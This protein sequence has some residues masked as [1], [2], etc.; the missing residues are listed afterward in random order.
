MN[1]KALSQAIISD[2][3]EAG[4]QIQPTQSKGFAWGIREA[5]WGSPEGQQVVQ[6]PK[7]PMRSQE[8]MKESPTE[9]LQKD[10]GTSRSN[11]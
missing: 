11:G 4:Q 10:A 7:M 6:A 8:E 1:D 3:K 5:I 9:V 2:L